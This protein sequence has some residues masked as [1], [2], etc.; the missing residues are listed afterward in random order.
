[1]KA[2]QKKF[3][4]GKQHKVKAFADDLSLIHSSPSVHQEELQ[5]IE[6]H[7]QDLDLKIR[8]DKCVSLAF[9]GTSMMKFTCPLSSG[10]TAPIQ[11]KPTKIL[12]QMIGKDA[13]T[14]RSAASTKLKSRFLT[15]LSNIDSRPIRGEYKAWILKN[16]LA[17]S[18]FFHLAVDKV[19]DSVLKKLQSQATKLLKKWLTLPRS[20]TLSVL[21][22]PFVMN[23]PHLP[24]LRDKAKLSL[25]ASIAS[26]S[27][28]LVREASLLLSDGDFTR[29]QCIPEHIYPLLKA[30]KDSV[31]SL[32]LSTDP[33]ATRALKAAA[34]KQLN[35]HNAAKWDAQLDGLQVQS[36]FKDIV[37][38]ESDC[39][40]WNRI[41]SGLPSKQMSFVLRAG[42]DTLPTPLNLA[43]W[44]IQ[45][46]P[47]CPLCGSRNPTTL[48]ILNSCVS[49]LNQGRYTWRHDSVL[50]C[51]VSWLT[52]TLGEDKCMY[53]DLPGHRA[54]DSPPATIPTD[55]LST[56]CRPDLF[57]CVGSTIKILELTVCSN[58]VE[59]FSNAR[60]R[61]Q[62]KQRYIE[63]VGL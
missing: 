63:M 61:K 31:D 13:T 10:P 15:A 27:D 21:F 52:P 44:K 30:A 1:M 55:I 59:G 54:S 7:C 34:A 58:T 46:N 57:L 51:I 23:F 26:S 56:S 43:R 53:A 12:G 38:L 48:H 42:S 35:T 49:A 37:T 6:S 8:P 17:P 45:S 62:C 22:H 16:Y 41:I 18:M 19:S 2:F 24:N 20:S 33:V 60:S 11:T 9:N 47:H 28:H 25:L 14:T 50:S 36:K 29:R 40:V 4:H 32:Q 5:I 3:I 39:P